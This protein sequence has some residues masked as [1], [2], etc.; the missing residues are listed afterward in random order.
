MDHALSE[1][2]AEVHACGTMPAPGRAVPVTSN[3]AST[4]ARQ[5]TTPE[6]IT[7]T[8][9][10]AAFTWQAFFVLRVD[11]ISTPNSWLLE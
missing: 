4:M 6:I 1:A 2:I 3:P 7:T 8:E 9:C 5:V 11:F 10:L